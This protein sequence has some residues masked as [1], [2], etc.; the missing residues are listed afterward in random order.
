MTVT[1]GV[2]EGCCSLDIED[3]LSGVCGG[4]ARRVNAGDEGN[5]ISSV[6]IG[7]PGPCIIGSY[8]L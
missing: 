7:K 3:E 5:G 8:C 1:V 6:L 4:F 2:S